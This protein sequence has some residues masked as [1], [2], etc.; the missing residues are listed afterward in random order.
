[1]KEILCKNNKIKKI[2]LALY[3]NEEQTAYETIKTQTPQKT[4]SSKSSQSS[5][6]SSSQKTPSSK[7]SQSSSQQQTPLPSLLSQEKINNINCDNITKFKQNQN[8]CWLDTFF[9]V[10]T[11]DELNNLFKMFLK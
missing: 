9:V 11:A 10:M 6:Q 2:Y 1:M 7:S 8:D 5:S 4:P 3:S